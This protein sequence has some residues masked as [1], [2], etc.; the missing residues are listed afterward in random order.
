MGLFL[1]AEYDMP[2]VARMT[3]DDLI[4]IGIQK[5]THRKRLKFELNRMI[6]RNPIPEHP[7][8]RS[9]M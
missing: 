8:V 2:T 1:A 5:P 7:P 9:I 4:A 6:I 3:P